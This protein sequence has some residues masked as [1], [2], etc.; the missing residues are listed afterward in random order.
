MVGYCTG[1]GNTIVT[2]YR[3]TGTRSKWVRHPR[4][5]IAKSVRKDA[6]CYILTLMI[7]EKLARGAVTLGVVALLSMSMFGVFHYGMSMSMDG[8][9]SNCPFM[10]G[11]NVCPMTPLEHVSFM[12]SFFTNIPPL[13]DPALALILAIAFVALVS[14]VWFRE[15][16][17]PDPLRSSGYFYRY[18][19]SSLPNLIQELFARGILN[20]KPF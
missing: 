5:D 19:N 16:F 6:F 10:P 18:R 11:M 7:H 8:T 20:P 2:L 12:Q 13:Q 9:M 3:N 17:T 1:M 4:C 14:V 15:F